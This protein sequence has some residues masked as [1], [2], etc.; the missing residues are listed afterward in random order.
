[1]CFNFILSRSNRK[2]ARDRSV[3]PAP[4]ATKVRSQL[5]TGS[6][7]QP[8]VT[9][10]PGGKPAEGGGG[11][12]GQNSGKPGRKA[13]T[14]PRTKITKVDAGMNKTSSLSVP[15]HGD[16][17]PDKRKK[18]HKSSG[19]KTAQT[20]HLLPLVDIGS[21]PTP[22]ISPIHSNNPTPEPPIPKKKIKVDRSSSSNSSSSSSSSS[23]SES[24]SEGEEPTLPVTA[25]V[26]QPLS[27]PVPTTTAPNYSTHQ[28]VMTQAP[29]LQQQQQPFPPRPYP[30][31][32]PPSSGRTSS[33]SS[34]NTSESD[35][36]SSSGSSSSDDSSDSSD[37]EN[38]TEVVSRDW[39]TAE[40]LLKDTAEIRTPLY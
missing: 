37:Q 36:D 31:Q 1:M 21:E 39:C 33:G 6:P 26:P 22:E 8:S 40:P 19:G 9:P 25:H 7:A 4:F 14:K 32:A 17:K 28:Q 2:L 29:H 16:A 5:P 11:A 10:P 34:S 20:Q 18:S 23:S 30:Q 3:S 13:Q 12:G 38:D 35:S 15:T 27:M 24:E